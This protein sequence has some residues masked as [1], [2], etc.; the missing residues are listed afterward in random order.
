[1]LG[2]DLE[3]SLL[4]LSKMQ[5]DGFLLASFNLCEHG[6][7]QFHTSQNLLDMSVTVRREFGSIYTSQKGVRV[8]QGN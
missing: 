1:M 8:G 2:V 5:V 3:L 7:P 6:R 4:R